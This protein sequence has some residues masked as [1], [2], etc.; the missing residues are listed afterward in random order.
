MKFYDIGE[1]PLMGHS[2]KC[3]APLLLGG[4]IAAGASLAGKG[5]GSNS[6]HT[7]TYDCGAEHQ[8]IICVYH[9]VPLV[10]WNLTGQNPQLTVSSISDFPQP[11]FEPNRILIF[12][13]LLHFLHTSKYSLVAKLSSCRPIVT[14]K[15][16]GRA[17]V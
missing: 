7:L 9:A 2:E 4:I 11:A 8:V 14:G 12:L 15:Q 13:T 5:V 1:S 17:H 10:D 16:I 6:G 3:I